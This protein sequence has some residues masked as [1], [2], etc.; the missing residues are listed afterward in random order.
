MES[1]LPPHHLV[2]H[3]GVA[4]DDLYNL[5]LL[6][7]PDSI[8]KTDFK[9]LDD[10]VIETPYLFQTSLY[11]I[12]E[13]SCFFKALLGISQP[14]F[15]ACKTQRLST[16]LD[17][18]LS[19]SGRSKSA[20]FTTISGIFDFTSGTITAILIVATTPAYFLLPQQF[21][22]CHIHK[23]VHKHLMQTVCHLLLCHALLQHNL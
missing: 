7:L 4:L 5:Y 1:V 19:I 21:T 11:K 14:A 23:A 3:A 10:V 6:F 2:N 12:I 8:F 15:I 18:I 9:R 20:H 17:T 13:I 16:V 22:V